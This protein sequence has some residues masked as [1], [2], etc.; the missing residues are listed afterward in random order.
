MENGL[1]RRSVSGKSKLANQIRISYVILL[2]PS[3]IFMAYAFYNMWTI[4]ERYKDML[5]SVVAA[6]EFSLDFK[7]DFD[8]ETY[9]LIVGNVA[10]ADSKIPEYLSDARE[11]VERLEDYTDTKD[12]RKRLESA[13][14]YLNNLETYI[15]R[16]EDNMNYEDRYEAN[17]TIWE[18]DVQIVTSLLQETINEYVYYENRQLQTAQQETSQFYFDIVKISTGLFAFIVI[19]IMVMSFWGPLWITRPIE[20]QVKN[21]QKQL[22]KAE[23]ELLQAQINPHFLY[24]TLD[25]IVWSAEAGN[26]KQ[27]VSMVGSLSDF[28]RSSLNKG[29]EIVTIRED[30][31]HVR[32]YLEIQQIRYQDI[33]SYEIDV[34]ETIYDYVI[35]KITI[36]PVVENAL[37]HG[38]KNRRG[39][40]KIIVTGGDLGEFIQITVKDDGMGISDE[41]LVS[42]REN[43]KS[44]KPEDNTIYGLYNINERIRLSFGDEYGVG[45][46]STEGVGTIVNIRLPKILTEIIKK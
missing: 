22:R 46:D 6:S 17:I 10:L 1:S 7:E 30:L 14:K 3:I 4:N 8:Y 35:P 29:K 11:V 32:S 37:Y 19:F 34:P 41:R 42:I 40:G 28:F 36:Q 23:F 38:I 24:N 9:L 44:D 26:Q 15:D 20:E 16:I 43:L 13:Q 31:Q 45:I 18:N 2:L 25:A 21:E 5:S 27:V 12:N 33:L 39:G